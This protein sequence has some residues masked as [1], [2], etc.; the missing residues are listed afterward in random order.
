MAIKIEQRER[1]REGMGSA[2]PRY[3]LWYRALYLGH[4]DSDLGKIQREAEAY[5]TIKVPSDVEGLVIV[6]R[7]EPRRG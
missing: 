2:S 4:A 6:D 3:E 7:G 5:A 1:P